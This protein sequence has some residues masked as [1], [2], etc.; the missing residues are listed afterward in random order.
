MK[1]TEE[2]RVLLWTFE[3]HQRVEA[4]GLRPLTP[5]AELKLFIDA[6]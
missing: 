4:R 1:R 5:E 3:G 2:R 6:L